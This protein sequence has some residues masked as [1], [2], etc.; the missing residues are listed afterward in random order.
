MPRST[1]LASR[2]DR[3]SEVRCPGWG[4]VGVWRG[5]LTYPNVRAISS[6]TSSIPYGAG[7]TSGRL[8]G[9][10]TVTWSPAPGRVLNP[11]GSRSPAMSPGVSGTPIWR[12]TRAMGTSSSNGSG[13]DPRRSRMPSQTPRAGT[14]SPRSWA[15]RRM[16][17]S[18]PQ[19]SQP[20]S[21][22]A[23]ASVRRPRR[24][25]VRAM[26]MGVK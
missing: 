12:W 24:L 6:M 13:T 17:A 16:E 1:L 5:T 26:A 18:I 23:E 25:E 19:G 9:T 7:R 22:R 21:K 15:K 14:L 10:T 3:C 2:R 8:V 11:M 4:Q 20:R